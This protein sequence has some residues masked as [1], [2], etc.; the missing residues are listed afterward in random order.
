MQT[1]APSPEDGF[2]P[3]TLAN[4]WRK[5]R[6]HVAAVRRPRRAEWQ[7]TKGV[8]CL[9]VLLGA[10]VQALAHERGE[11]QALQGAL[12]VARADLATFKQQVARQQAQRGAELAEVTH[13][14]AGR[15]VRAMSRLRCV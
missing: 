10:R 14:C 5:A 4:Q 12:E 13:R 1:A 11:R 2:V 15:R 7:R 6:G 9:V 8:V 3:I